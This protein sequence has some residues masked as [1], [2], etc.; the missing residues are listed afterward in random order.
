MSVYSIDSSEL[1]H[2]DFDLNRRIDAIR[3]CERQLNLPPQKSVECKHKW[4]LFRQKCQ[5]CHRWQIDIE[6]ERYT[7]MNG[8][9][10]RGVYLPLFDLWD[11]QIEGN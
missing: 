1:H 11:V 7:I 8:Q 6:R 3:E 9:K 2:P 4:E 5:I 10:Y